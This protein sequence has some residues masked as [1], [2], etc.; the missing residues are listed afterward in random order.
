MFLFNKYYHLA[1]VNSSSMESIFTEN[2]WVLYKKI[3]KN[4]QEIKHNDIVL[5]KQYGKTYIKRVIALPGDTLKIKNNHVLINSRPHKEVK[6]VKFNEILYATVDTF[7]AYQAKNFPK[8]IIPF[9]G[10][11]ITLN[12]STL[13]HYHRIIELNYPLK[14][15]KKNEFYLINNQV[16]NT[17]TFA[18]DFYFV[19]GDNRLRSEDSRHFGPVKAEN[20]FGKYSI[21]VW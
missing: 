21:K 9:P 19:M 16:K 10:F 6:T 12:D 11:K 8:F 5:F 3:D 20:I 14:I 1:R 15:E 18:D 7:P 4:K 17:L 13:N 2:D